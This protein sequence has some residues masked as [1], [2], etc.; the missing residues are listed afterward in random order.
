MT[1]EIH[2]YKCFPKNQSKEK[3]LSSSGGLNGEKF[4]FLV[5][6]QYIGECLSKLWIF[7]QWTCD[8]YILKCHEIFGEIKE[9]NTILF[10]LNYTI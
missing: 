2:T 7:S 6:I 10:R 1:M 4:K 8:A 3:K 5:N 9:N